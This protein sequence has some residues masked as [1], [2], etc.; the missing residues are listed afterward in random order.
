MRKVYVTVEV[1]LI[2]QQDDGIETSE[3]MEELDYN[4]TSQTEGA[5]VVDTEIKNWK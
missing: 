3:V 1:R 5:E 4:F 2:V